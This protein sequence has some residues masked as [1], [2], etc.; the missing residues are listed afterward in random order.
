MFLLELFC[1]P[2]ELFCFLL[3]L[4]CFLLELFCFLLELF[5]FLSSFVSSSFLLEIRTL[6]GSIRRGGRAIPDIRWGWA[7]RVEGKG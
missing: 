1:F 3:E 7:L 6:R 4:F 2:L 5:C